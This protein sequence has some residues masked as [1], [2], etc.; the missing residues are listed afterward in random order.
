[1]KLIKRVIGIVLTIFMIMAWCSL[2]PVNEAKADA[3]CTF[4]ID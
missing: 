3:D 2:F 4:W 1:M